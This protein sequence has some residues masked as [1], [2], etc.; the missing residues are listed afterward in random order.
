MKAAQLPK[1]TIVDDINQPERARPVLAGGPKQIAGAAALALSLLAGF[2]PAAQAAEQL[3]IAE[4]FGIVYLL[5]NVARD[6]GL[7]EK[8]GKQAGVDIEVQWIKLSGGSAVNN[9]LLSGSIDI[10][11]AGVGPLLTIWDRTRGKQDV[12]GI[13][14]L[15]NLPTYLVTNNPKVQT[16]ADFGPNDR[17]A[18]PA[19]G[20]SVQA[21]YLQMAAARLW[22]QDQ[23][24]KL[25]K[26]T[27]ALPHPDAAAAIISGGTEITGHFANP[28]YQN[29]ELA[30]NPN[31]R[32]IL[33]SYDV[34]GGPG[35]ST[36]LFSTARFRDEHRKVYDAFVDALQDAE[37]FVGANPEEAADIYIRTT[38]AKIDRDFLIK[39]IKDPDIQYKTT[40]QNTYA[41]AEFMHKVG[42]IKNLPASWKDYFFEDARTK[43]GS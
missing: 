6:Q 8:Q 23:Y 3:R 7:I 30:Q 38:G 5:L 2:M 13:A 28:P 27:V 34:L 12:R 20:V 22:G 9:A 41:L 37:K 26:I 40:P 21:R 1:S 43:G 14:S 32:K 15:G 42:A 11:A 29:Q 25:D 36:V 18:L 16:I 39:I 35:S 17:I 31:A 10:A 4:Q 19:V 33:T 24:N